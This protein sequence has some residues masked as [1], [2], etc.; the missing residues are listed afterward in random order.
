MEIGLEN[1]LKKV[2][3]IAMAFQVVMETEKCSFLPLPITDNVEIQC[4]NCKIQ[5]SLPLPS[6]ANP[7]NVFLLVSYI[8]T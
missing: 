2:Y 6:P 4:L 5:P 7:P 8:K 3:R 1:T